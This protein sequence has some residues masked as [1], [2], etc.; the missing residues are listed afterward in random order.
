MVG[1]TLAEIRKHVEALASTDGTYVVHCG[2]TGERPIPT[3]GKSFE[4]RLVAE[5][6]V[7]AATQYRAALRRYDPRLPQYDLTVSQDIGSYRSGSQEPTE[8][9]REASPSAACDTDFGSAT[10]SVHSPLVEFCHRVAAGVFET[11]CESGHRAVET[12]VMHVYFDLAESVRHPDELCLC[13]L[14]SIAAELT[15]RL[16]PAE[17]ASVLAETVTRLPPIEAADDPVSATLETLAARGF[18]ST[19]SQSPSSVDLDA[20]RR[21]VVVRVSE[22]ALSPRADHLPVLPF[23]VELSRHRPEWPLSSLRVVDTDDGWTL[24]LV[25]SRDDAP[26]GLASVPIEHSEEDYGEHNQMSEDTD[27]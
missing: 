2:R 15:H 5:H 19:Y 4:S 1:A 12:A 23:V 18:L 17:Q 26:T 25:Q 21:S 11:L 14:E 22:Y 9:P 10:P 7:Y 6:A 20:G 8:S 3:A 24:V 27:R 16:T 13:L